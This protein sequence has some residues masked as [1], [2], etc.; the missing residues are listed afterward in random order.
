MKYNICYMQF[1]DNV[2][3]DNI[4]PRYNQKVKIDIDGSVVILTFND[5]GSLN[6][7]GE[8]MA[9]D[10]RAAIKFAVCTI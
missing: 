5:P 4:N 10:I 2:V 6:A 7:M 1:D 9:N 8:Q 3:K